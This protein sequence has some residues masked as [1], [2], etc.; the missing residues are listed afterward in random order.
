M[1][2]NRFARIFL[3]AMIALGTAGAAMPTAASARDMYSG[4]YQRQQ[5]GNHFDNRR[6]DNRQSRHG[7]RYDRRRSCSPHEAVRKAHWMGV[8][9]AGI[10]RVNHRVIVVFGHHRGH[11]ARVVFDRHSPRCRVIGARGI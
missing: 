11:P 2:S 3:T 10:A 7:G 1:K 6:W 9:R 4:G 5:P 8:R